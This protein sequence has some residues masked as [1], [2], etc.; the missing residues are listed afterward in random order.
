MT[1]YWLQQAPIGD[2]SFAGTNPLTPFA[3]HAHAQTIM[4]A[5]DT[6]Y[7]RGI[8]NNQVF[9]IT[10][11]GTAG[12]PISYLPDPAYIGT[13]EI[14]GAYVRPTVGTS[15]L[16]A[17]T[18]TKSGYNG[19]VEIHADHIVFGAIPVRRSS[20]RG[21]LVAGTSTT[22]VLDVVID[23]P[24]VHDNRNSGVRFDSAKDC[25]MINTEV[26]HSGDFYPVRRSSSIVNWPSA[27]G[28]I[29]S[30]NITFD[31]NRI[32]QNYG[33]GLV[34][35]RDSRFTTMMRN[36]L[37]DN[38][39]VNYYVQQADGT[40][41]LY[42]AGFFLDDSVLSH[43]DNFAINNEKKFALDTLGGTLIAHNIGVGGVYNVSILGGQGDL[44]TSAIQDVAVMF[45]TFANAK[46][47][48]SKIGNFGSA[49]FIANN[50]RNIFYYGNVHRQNTGKFT[51]AS[52]D[53]TYYTKGYNSWVGTATA[54]T[55]VSDATDV[56]GVA[57]VAPDFSFDEVTFDPAKY[58][59][60]A[61]HAIPV[62]STLPAGMVLP[63]LDYDEQARDGYT[64]GGWEFSPAV[65]GG[66]DP[67]T[68]GTIGPYWIGITCP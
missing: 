67:G 51:N 6:L 14:D 11:P 23:G 35:G 45:N 40:R 3:T 64:V 56:T 59:L 16:L 26:Y 36:V 24:V 7:V 31:G 10:K 2:D 20:G 53:F 54:P 43:A 39:A 29:N 47:D 8:I 55:Q 28:A 5:G 50:H 17:P 34:A 66:G 37:W 25:R 61:E 65:G 13:I 63:A 68:P 38:M 62:P 4:V 30:E 42:N 48:P 21:I 58:K 27:V 19:L 9:N 44:A 18:G 1:T 22:K 15:F 46:E 41:I 60:T 33:E 32:H 49:K 12:S 57:L 52:G